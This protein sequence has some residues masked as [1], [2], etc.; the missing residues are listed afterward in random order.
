MAV[1]MPANR[2]ETAYRI[3][4]ELLALPRWSGHVGPETL[5]PPLQAPAWYAE[6]LHRLGLDPDVW[7]TIYHHRLRAPAEIAEWMKGSVLRPVLARLTPGQ[8]GE[9]LDE[10]G[11]RLEASY[12]ASASGVLFPFRRLFFVARKP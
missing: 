7:E 5:S 8:A 10:F 11:A 12:P 4:L 1:Q 9:F 3:L 2:E 6:Q